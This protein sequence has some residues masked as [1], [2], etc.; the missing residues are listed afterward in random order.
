MIA[1]QVYGR[2]AKVQ[3]DPNTIGELDKIQLKAF[4]AILAELASMKNLQKK[5]LLY[6]GNAFELL[7]INWYQRIGDRVSS[8]L[9]VTKEAV[10][11]SRDLDLTDIGL[12]YSDVKQVLDQVHELEESLSARKDAQ[13]QSDIAAKVPPDFES[14]LRELE[15]V[16]GKI[17]E[18]EHARG[19][20]TKLLAFCKKRIAENKKARQIADMDVHERNKRGAAAPVH[21]PADEV[22]LNKFLKALRDARGN[23][24]VHKEAILIGYQFLFHI[25]VACYKQSYHAI[26]RAEDNPLPRALY[27]AISQS[28]RLAVVSE[29]FCDHVKVKPPYKYRLSLRKAI[30]NAKSDMKRFTMQERERL[31]NYFKT[32]PL[33][34]G[35][36]P[37]VDGEVPDEKEAADLDSGPLVDTQE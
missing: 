18:K 17:F 12:K 4:A 22:F 36:R 1:T 31:E 3:R 25:L 28:Y 2:L 19:I 35:G 29:E 15:R 30:D 32:W 8:M 13:V 10:P 23:A 5:L 37:I 6:T 7:A 9:A 27:S 14:N 21:D 24:Y 11:K 16:S 26:L 33:H 20:E 34:A